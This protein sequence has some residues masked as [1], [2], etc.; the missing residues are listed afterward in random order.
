LSASTTLPPPGE[1]E[2][3]IEITALSYG[4]YGIGRLNGK[5]IMIPHTAPGDRIIA[6][7]LDSQKHYAIGAMVRMIHPSTLRQTPPCPYVGRC[8][9]CSWQHVVYE[10]QLRAKQQSV[11]DALRRIGK[12]DDFEIRPIIAALDP[13]RYRR[14]IRLQT[15]NA[16]RLGLYAAA[17]HDLVEIDSCAIADDRLNSTIEPLRRWLANINSAI[18]HLEIIAGDGSDELV[19]VARIHSRLDPGDEPSCAGL[20]DGRDLIRGLIVLDPRERKTWGEPW[21][22]VNLTDALTVTLDADVFTQVNAA[23]N[24]QMISRLLALADFRVDDQVLE[25]YS[26][27]GNFTLPMATRVEK[28]VAVEGHRQAVANG[29]LNAQ[30]YRLDNID[31]QCAAVPQAVAR[32]KRQRRRF[33]KIVL[34]PPRA[35][36]KGVT[37]ELASFGAEMICYLSCNPTTMARD[38]AALAAR[39]YKLRLVQP[40][41][42]FPHTFHVESLAIMIHGY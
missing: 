31:W 17:S 40:I 3:S 25:L 22:T 28:I 7:V 12:L 9:G 8:G 41:D 34:D 10:T 23:G 42:L 37:G 14:R 1:S 20:I 39:G 15:T 2:Q 36:A 6:R 35:G 19:V 16:K 18:E 38:L 26:G 33:S 27:A 11:E 13:Y 32:F 24:C 4:P 5:A 21:I 30:K 29:K